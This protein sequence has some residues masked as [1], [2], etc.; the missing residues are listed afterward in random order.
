MT[1]QRQASPIA[2]YLGYDPAIAAIRLAADVAHA[3]VSRATGRPTRTPLH[4]RERIP[5]VQTY[6]YEL[7]MFVLERARAK[8]IDLTP[9]SHPTAEPS[10]SHVAAAPRPT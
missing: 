8:R 5:Y 7:P 3:R 4:I 1:A 6:P 10:L 9:S 2:S